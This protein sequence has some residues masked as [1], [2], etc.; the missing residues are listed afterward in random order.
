MR[1]FLTNQQRAAIGDVVAES[2]W[3]EEVVAMAISVFTGVSDGSL[4]ALLSGR[5]IDAKL[6]ILES[7]AETD[8]VRPQRREGLRDLVATLR[9]LNK[10]RVTVVH[11]MWEPESGGYRLGDLFTGRAVADVVRFRGRGRER[12]LTTEEVV[13][14]ADQIGAATRALLGLLRDEWIQREQEVAL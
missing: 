13:A 7:L 9:D 14:L 8:A 2:T 4:G 10:D 3:M 1:E 11:G 6:Q 5:M 12:L